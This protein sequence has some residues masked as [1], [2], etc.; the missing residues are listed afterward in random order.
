MTAEQAKI[1]CLFFHRFA[2]LADE[3]LTAFVEAEENQVSNATQVY[4]AK[5]PASR[6]MNK[7]EIA[8]HLGVSV[9]TVSNLIK[10][11]LPTVPLGQRRIQFNCEEVLLWAK[12]REVKRSG[13][14]KL[15]AVS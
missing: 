10:D 9:R 3:T 2:D 11:G 13:K 7:A 15:R 12:N 1:L 8:D 4:S 14:A 6:L 5:Q